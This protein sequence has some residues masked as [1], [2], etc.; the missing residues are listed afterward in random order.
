MK[1]LLTAAL[2]S[3]ALVATSATAQAATAKPTVKAPAAT[4]VVEKASAKKMPTT[5]VKVLTPTT[6]K[7]N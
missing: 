1:K 5:K 4:K 3:V 6:K 7:K 2:I